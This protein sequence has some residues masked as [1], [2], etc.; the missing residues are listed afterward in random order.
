MAK[1]L[2]L[3]KAS[4]GLNVKVDPTRIE[5]NPELGVTD[6]SAAYNIVLDSTG[7]VSRRKGYEQKI[8]G[9]YHSLF[10]CGNYA[11]GVTGDALQVIEHDWSTSNIRNVTKGARMDYVREDEKVYYSN[12]FEIG[13]IKDK[14][15]YGW[16]D[17]SYVGPDT[18]RTF[19][20]PPAGHLLE[21]YAGRMYVAREN[22][23]F[24]SEPLAYGR[25]DLARGYIPYESRIQLVKAVSNG[26]Y[27][28]DED[29]IFFEG[30]SGPRDFIH[31]VVADYPAILRAVAVELVGGSRFGL[32]TAAMFA[33]LGTKRGLCI[34][35]PDAT[36]INLTEEKLA[37]PD[38][39]R[40]SALVRDDNILFL[41][42][43]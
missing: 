24:F 35:G 2:P 39:S 3:L 27:V 38:V 33:V 40:G 28:G 42:E 26:I 37:Y 4:T 43:D 22:V 7:R 13:Y 41:F 25:F 16:Q 30:G 8:S 15:S 18:V 10:S 6:L 12:G 14:L 1:T 9:N 29:R 5:Y 11:V 31:S 20:S 32:Q 21:I 23:L 17:Q 36:F 19:S 34:A